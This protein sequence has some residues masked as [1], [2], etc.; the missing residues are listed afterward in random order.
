MRQNL[1]NIHEVDI[2]S[3]E[4]FYVIGS[5]T[6]DGLI[7]DRSN[8]KLDIK[9]VSAG[10]GTSSEDAEKMYE[11]LFGQ[12]PYVVTGSHEEIVMAPLYEVFPP[13]PPALPG[14]QLPPS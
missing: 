7:D 4:H 12:T 14:F 11:A 1:T 3:V 8:V 9:T 5:T 2:N 6:K 13:K 10:G